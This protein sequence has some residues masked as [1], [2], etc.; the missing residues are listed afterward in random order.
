[1]RE[2]ERER[3]REIESEGKRESKTQ[4]KCLLMQAQGRTPLLLVS[5]PWVVSY[6]AY[7]LAL[8]GFRN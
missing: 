3:E 5:L 4:G 8:G 1:M 6:F 2:R 7:L